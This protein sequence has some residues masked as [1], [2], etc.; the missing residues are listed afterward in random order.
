MFV[1]AKCEWRIGQNTRTFIVGSLTKMSQN[2]GSLG[3]HFKYNLQNTTEPRRFSCGSMCIT[4]LFDYERDFK[5][6]VKNGTY[7]S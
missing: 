7:R 6:I 1:I 3:V 2:N 4:S 5:L